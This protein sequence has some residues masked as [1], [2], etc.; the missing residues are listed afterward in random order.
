M[1]VMF[2]VPETYTT[3]ETDQLKSELNEFHCFAT[4]WSDDLLRQTQQLTTSDSGSW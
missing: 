1:S 4:K 3:Q 2:A